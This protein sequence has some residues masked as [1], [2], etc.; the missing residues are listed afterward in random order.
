VRAPRVV[1]DL[2]FAEPDRKVDGEAILLLEHILDLGA[3]ELD[4]VLE[5]DPIERQHERG[6]EERERVGAAQLGTRQRALHAFQA[7]CLGDLRAKDEALPDDDA[8]LPRLPHVTYTS[9]RPAT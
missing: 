1:D 2:D 6:T 4:R 9:F 5:L 7:T 8:F 3:R